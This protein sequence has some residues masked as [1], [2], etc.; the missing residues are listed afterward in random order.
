MQ[1]DYSMKSDVQQV[2]SAQQRK[3]LV[4]KIN[5]T[6]KTYQDKLKIYIQSR[7][8]L[9]AAAEANKKAA[10]AVRAAR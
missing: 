8:Q 9:R 10:R 4:Q 1:A 5:Q 2:D 3:L 7:K 6:K